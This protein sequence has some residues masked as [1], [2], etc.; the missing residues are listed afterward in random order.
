[1][2]STYLHIGHFKTGTTALQTWCSRE[3]AR[4]YDAG[5][6]YPLTGRA[7]ENPV[8]HAALALE[9][10]REHGGRVPGWYCEPQSLQRIQE[11]MTAELALSPSHDVLISSEE[12]WRIVEL[13]QRHA[14]AEMVVELLARE[15]ELKV[16]FCWREPL[17]WL[18][19][20]YNQAQKDPGYHASFL[21]YVNALPDSYLDPTI[22]YRFWAELLGEDAVHVLPYTK[23]GP[24]HLARILEHCGLNDMPADG[25]PGDVNPA[26]DE[27]RMERARLGKILRQVS[28]TRAGPVYRSALLER[29][30]ALDALKERLQQL[31][32]RNREFCQRFLPD[33]DPWLDL[34]RV[35]LQHHRLQGLRQVAMLTPAML[36]SPERLATVLRDMAAALEQDDPALV[37]ALLESAVLLAPDET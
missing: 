34:E 20:W 6:L 19:S 30:E 17:D 13:E 9:L 14:A 21:D 27:R 7:A 24:A 31:A 12:L 16:F 37:S 4:L 28:L 35:L 29:P 5:L 23:Q 36:S 15:R 33:I 22:N 1:M 3:Q 2:A 26:L 18:C 10:F 25:M 32:Q 11:S 8:A